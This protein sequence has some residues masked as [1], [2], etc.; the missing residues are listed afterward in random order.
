MKLIILLLLTNSAFAQFKITG[1]DAAIMGLQFTA[2][3]AQG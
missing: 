2:G 3:Y 1:N